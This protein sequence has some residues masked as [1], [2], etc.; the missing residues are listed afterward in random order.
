MG[1]SREQIVAAVDSGG[2]AT[3]EVNVPELGGTV[4][5]RELTGGL[6]N[7]FEVAIAQA[8][9]K[10]GAQAMQ[11]VTLD[12]LA[13]CVLDDDGNKLLDS[14]LIR[15]LWNKKPKAVFRL[16]EAIIGVSA[17]SDED[18]ESMAENFGEAPSDGSSSDSP[19]TSDSQ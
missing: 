1:L 5:V 16:R 9:T 3:T 15:Q 14:N 7:D 19:D 12:M 8:A 10:S 11:K 17:M 4:T 2:P 18:A 6:R 13:V